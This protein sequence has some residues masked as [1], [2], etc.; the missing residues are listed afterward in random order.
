MADQLDHI[1][2]YLRG[3]LSEEEIT[4]FEALMKAD[5]S[6]KKQVEEH[7]QLLK[8][9][10][11]S[12]NRELKQKLIQVESNIEETPA[13]KSRYPIIGLAAAIAAL[14]V[15]FVTFQDEKISSQDLYAQHYKVYP[16]AELPVLRSENN[17]DNPYAYYEKREYAT[18]L[19]LFNKMQA[20]DPDNSALLFYSALCQ[21]EL[22]HP[23]T[24]IE[25][26]A[27]VISR[28]DPDYKRPALWYQS[29]A[30]LKI[31]KPE[32]AMVILELL[33]LDDDVYAR[34]ANELL[35]NL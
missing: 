3:E 18:A 23:E 16:N 27:L 33:A 28:E 1:E 8:G 2:L 7:R 32:N 12:F 31:E 19:E 9:I 14:I 20:S 15:V 6:L 4:D 10:E 5:S 21:L 30:Y 35:E 24:G 22:D 11:I 34:K 13:P 25:L 17:E 29:L 26:F